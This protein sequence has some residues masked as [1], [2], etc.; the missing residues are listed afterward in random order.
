MREARTGFQSASAEQA[1]R[2]KT[3]LPDA[4]GNTGRQG[5]A[6][7]TDFITQ[8]FVGYDFTRSSASS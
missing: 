5:R 4:T 2:Y 7:S 1:T 3:G 8:L 6:P